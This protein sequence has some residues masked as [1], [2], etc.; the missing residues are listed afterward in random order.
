MYLCDIIC[1]PF[2]RVKYCEFSPV[3]C[4]CLAIAVIRF[5]KSTAALD[6]SKKPDMMIRHVCQYICGTYLKLYIAPNH[7]EN[8]T[9]VVLINWNILLLFTAYILL[10]ISK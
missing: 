9:P 3:K 4:Y 2:V 10:R 7:G 1:N 6:A 5:K 8:D